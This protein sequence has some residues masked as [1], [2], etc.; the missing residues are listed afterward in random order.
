MPVSDLHAVRSTRISS[1]PAKPRGGDRRGKEGRVSLYAAL[2]L[3][4]SRRLGVARTPEDSGKPYQNP[5]GL[6]VNPTN[7][8]N[9]MV[10]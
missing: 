5:N 1:T 4:T 9:G 6:H 10:L 3:T 8:P 2:R 7:T